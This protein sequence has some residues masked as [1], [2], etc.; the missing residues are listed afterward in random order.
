MAQDGSKL[1]LGL[2]DSGEKGFAEFMEFQLDASVFKGDEADLFH[3]IRKHAMG[4]GSLPKRKTIKKWANENACTIPTKE[5]IDESPKYYLDQI[6][7]R[8]LKL[9]LKG[10][11]MDA[12]KVRLSNPQASL[13]ALTSDIIRLNQNSKRKQ[14]LNFAEGGDKVVHEEFI[15]TQ[16]NADTGLKFGW[17]TFD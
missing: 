11:M 2:V 12:E 16:L 9:G 5:A 7:T 10:A 14:L 1:L 6:E 13:Q 8:N 3:F 4:Y 15:K 17:P